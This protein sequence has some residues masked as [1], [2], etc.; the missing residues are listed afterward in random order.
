VN[1]MKISPLLTWRIDCSCC[2][3]LEKCM[4]VGMATWESSKESSFSS[5][6]EWVPWPLDVLP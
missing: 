3:F 4:L 6:F 2:P 5:L 1:R